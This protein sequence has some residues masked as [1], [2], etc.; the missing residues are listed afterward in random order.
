MK[1]Q[2]FTMLTTCLRFFCEE[3]LRIGGRRPHDKPV[4]RSS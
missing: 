3:A 1:D 2:S 4:S